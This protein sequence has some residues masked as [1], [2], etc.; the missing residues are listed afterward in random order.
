MR[1]TLIAIAAAALVAAPA[2]SENISDPEEIL[3]ARHGYMLL[4]ANQLAP[5]GAM[6]KGEMPYDAAT[7]ARAAASLA[8]LASVDTSML[9]APGTEEGAIEDSSA[10]P[11]I[12]SNT[13]DREARFAELTT[14]SHTLSAAAGTDL[15][16]LKAAMGAVGQACGGCHKQ[17][18][19]SE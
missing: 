7:A 8:A 5:L 1:K 3:T 18:R 10:L 13:A 15:E 4:L 9:W 17:Y 19:K 14:A 11:E 6:A 16:G 12:L 2:L